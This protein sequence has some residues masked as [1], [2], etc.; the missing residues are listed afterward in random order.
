MPLS[1]DNQL[2]NIL[3]IGKNLKKGAKILSL[4][5][6]NYGILKSLKDIKNKEDLSKIK[7]CLIAIT[8]RYKKITTP[9]TEQICKN[10][11]LCKIKIARTDMNRLNAKK[12]VNCMIFLY[13]MPVVLWYKLNMRSVALIKSLAAYL[14][15]ILNGNF[16]IILQYHTP[17]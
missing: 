1:T 10:I 17:T 3:R 8:S 7:I 5:Q 12:M 11:G 6:P 16:R 13:F 9:T 15:V 4:K 2:S 14:Y